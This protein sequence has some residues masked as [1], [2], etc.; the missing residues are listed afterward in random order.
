M[1]FK[2]LINE[3]T[4]LLNDMIN[5]L[6]YPNV[7]FSV[8]EPPRSD[9]CDVYSN[10]AFQLSRKLKKKPFDIAREIYEKIIKSYLQT[11]KDSMISSV[12]AHPAGYLNFR[13]NYTKLT[14]ETLLMNKFEQGMPDIGKNKHVLI[15]HTSVNPNKALHVGHIRNVVLGDCVYRILQYTNHNAYVLNYVDDSGLQVA[16]IIVGFKFVNLP[17][18]TDKKF[19]HYCGDDVYVKVN[20]MY[21]QNTSLVENSR[22]VLREIEKSDSEIAKFAKELTTKVLNEQLKT[23]WRLKV[24]YDCLNFESQ[25]IQSRLWENVL[26]AMKKKEIVKVEN[27]SESKHLGCL[28][29]QGGLDGEEKVLLRSDGTATYIAKDIPYAAWKIGLVE[30]PF[31]YYKYTTQFDKTTLL[32]T[33][34][35]S[36]NE[37]NPG[38][39]AADLAITVIDARQSRLQ[40]IISKVLYMLGASLL[41]YVHLSYEVV[42]LS[43][44]TAKMLD[45][46]IDNK[47]SA[48]MSGRK[49]I[50]VNADNLLDMLHKIAYEAAKLRNPDADNIWLERV[51]E[52]IAIAAIRYSMIKQ[53][54][55]KTITFDIKESLNLEGDTGPYLQ[56]SHA[57]ACRIIEKSMYPLMTIDH[58]LASTLKTKHEIALIKEISKFE[59]HLEDATFNLSPKS[60]ARYAYS[61]ATQFNAFYEKVPVLHEENI[62]VSKARLILVNTFIIVMKT[63]LNLIGIDALEKM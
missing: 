35:D 57:R 34:L 23:C 10:I 62:E 7:D 24:R 2:F 32:A 54:L 51:A 41:R 63:S 27:N 43:S 29:I 52:S 14:Y 59:M 47:Q 39:H 15:E 9:L 33:K 6:N 20:E 28:V 56:Y 50:Y 17:M 58:D 26:Q 45:I 44:D 18:Q 48:H 53:D 3:I 19:D 40:N 16:D 13:A 49:G 11:K 55:D 4:S 25:I 12:E 1:T 31:G 61:L 60:I 22:Y 36:R 21:K 37:S 46:S 5:E 8:D 38:F 42:T 30:D